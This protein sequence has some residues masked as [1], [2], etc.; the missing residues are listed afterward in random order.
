M[1]SHG[2]PKCKQDDCSSD[3]NGSLGWCK[4]HYYRFYR[5]GDPSFVIRRVSP[6]GIRVR[7][8]HPLYGTYANMMQRCY[9]ETCK[10][11]PIYGGRG[12]AVCDRWRDDFLN[13]AE[14]MGERPAAHTLD[15][16]DPNGDYSPGNCRWADHATQRRNISKEG[17]ERQKAAVR[18]WNKRRW[19]GGVEVQRSDK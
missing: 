4:K 10:D 1:R 6:K 12:I 19:H 2:K 5:Y 15:R 3:A 14:D 7:T 9:S 13:F 16:I 8:D 17:A 11:Y 18:A